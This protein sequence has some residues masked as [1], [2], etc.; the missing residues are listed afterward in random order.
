MPRILVIDSLARSGTTLLAALINSQSGSASLRAMFYEGM[1][2]ELGSWPYGLAQLPL[3][4]ADHPLIV[5]AGTQKLVLDNPPA[6]KAVSD[7][8]AWLRLKLGLPVTLN[9]RYLL[10][11]SFERARS[12]RQTAL[13]DEEGWRE[14]LDRPIRNLADLD[15]L[16][17]DICAAKG[18]RVLGLRWNQ[19]LFYAPKWLRRPEH[20]WCT[21]VRNPL[22]RAASAKLTHN[23]PFEKSL[24]SSLAYAKKITLMQGHKNFRCVYYEDLVLDPAGTL[25]ALFEWL[26]HPLGA[27]ELDEV[28]GQHGEPYRSETAELTSQTGD[29]RA[30]KDYDGVYKSAVGRHV[31]VVPPDIAAEMVSKLSA[32]PIYS[33]Y[34][35][36]AL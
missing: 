11:S 19:G 18:L 9:S 27:V 35:P 1:A 28:R 34:W 24:A 6:R 13:F 32:S 12:L 20:Y 22:D 3:L 25:N 26:G 23:W 31:N 21:I 2:C 14:C 29:H 33:R 5:R 8:V 17:Q 36:E 30:G 4:R 16:Y 7:K 15:K 10:S